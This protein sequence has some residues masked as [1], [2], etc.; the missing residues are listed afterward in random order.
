MLDDMDNK[1][2]MQA[3]EISKGVKSKAANL[4]GLNRTTLI[5]KMNK[6]AIEF[7]LPPK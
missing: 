5:E 2:I 3:L 6:K 1:M 4:L 7:S